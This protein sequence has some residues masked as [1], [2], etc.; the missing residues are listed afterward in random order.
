LSA[1]LYG[2]EMNPDFERRKQTEDISEQ[3][4]EENI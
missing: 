2:S 3:G 1:V 4:A